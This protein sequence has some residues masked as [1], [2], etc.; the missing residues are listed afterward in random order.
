MTEALS[1]DRELEPLPAGARSRPPTYPPAPPGCGEGGRGDGD[2]HR[3]PVM[4]RFLLNE[5]QLA[6]AAAL[7]V[8]QTLHDEALIHLDWDARELSGTPRVRTALG[9]LRTRLRWLQVNSLLNLTLD[10]QL[11]REY[12]LQILEMAERPVA[13][14]EL[15]TRWRD[16]YE[17]QLGAPLLSAWNACAPEDPP[18]FRHAADAR[19]IRWMVPRLFIHGMVQATMREL[20]Q[21]ENIASPEPFQEA[22]L[23]PI[24]ALLLAAIDVNY[25]PQR[26]RDLPQ[27]FGSRRAS[28]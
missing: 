2:Q 5:L 1:H 3:A 4:E 28:E 19:A 26:T 14:L 20:D 16:V 13:T 22:V 6:L 17:W 15:A 8:R 23:N 9:R 7:Y 12:K 18:P 21:P 25:A 11:T 27:S 24:F 10:R